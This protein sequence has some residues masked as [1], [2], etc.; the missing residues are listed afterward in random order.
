MEQNNFFKFGNILLPFL[1]QDRTL[2]ELQHEWTTLRMFILKGPVDLHSNLL[3]I[4]WWSNRGITQLWLWVL[5][6]A[7][8]VMLLLLL[9]KNTTRPEFTTA[10][11]RCTTSQRKS[12]IWK[13]ICLLAVANNLAS[14]TCAYI[15][16]NSGF[17]DKAIAMSLEASVPSE[18]QKRFAWI[19]GSGAQWMSD[20]PQSGQ[21][22][23]PWRAVKPSHIG[24]GGLRKLTVW[25]GKKE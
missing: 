6:T 25:Q 1:P 5:L 4:F 21:H 24:G 7:Y 14:I 20:S 8:K 10:V 13:G 19:R 11:K 2:Y 23:S 12:V 17:S 18:N 16:S 3:R 9:W 15:K 22:L